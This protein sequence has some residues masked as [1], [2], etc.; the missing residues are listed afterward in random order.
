MSMTFILHHKKRQVEGKY[1]KSKR[2]HLKNHKNLLIG[3]R[4]WKLMSFNDF[5]KGINTFTISYRIVFSLRV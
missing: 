3:K 5:V 4:A 2:I 1:S